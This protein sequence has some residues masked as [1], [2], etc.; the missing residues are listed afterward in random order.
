MTMVNQDEEHLRLLSIL[1]YI[2]GGLVACGSCFGALYAIIG[3]G[4]MTA[5]ATQGGH[6]GPPAFVGVMFFLVGAFIVL[7][8]GTIAVLSILTGRNLA[9]KQNHTFCFV[10][11]CLSC[12]SVPLGTALGVFTIVVLMRPSVKQL[13]GQTPAPV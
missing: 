3:G 6:D 13:F 4:V 9:R 11:A 2:W 5:A 12:L 8:V 1:Y 10:I 7:V